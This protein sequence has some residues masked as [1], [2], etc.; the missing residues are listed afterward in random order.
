MP[1]DCSTSTSVELTFMQSQPIQ[2]PLH[3]EEGAAKVPTYV[4]TE[5]Q[6]DVIKPKQKSVR[7][8]N[9]LVHS[10]KGFSWN[11]QDHTPS[12]FKQKKT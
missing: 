3:M 11:P 1:Q 9:L 5:C 4:P 2:D 7:A 10:T 6:G 8:F 12:V